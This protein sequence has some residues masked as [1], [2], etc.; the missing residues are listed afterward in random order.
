MFPTH[1]QP[2]KE[3]QSYACSTSEMNT[4]LLFRSVIL[5][6]GGIGTEIGS[7]YGDAIDQADDQC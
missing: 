7:I 2:R 5:I 1:G 6:D 3:T 4:S